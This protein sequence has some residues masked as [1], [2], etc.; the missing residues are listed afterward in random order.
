MAVTS[1]IFYT[2]RKKKTFRFTKLTIMT[3]IQIELYVI[4]SLFGLL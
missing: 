1:T 2:V 3:Q 4:D